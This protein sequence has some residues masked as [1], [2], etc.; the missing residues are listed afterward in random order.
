MKWRCREKRRGSSRKEAV[1]HS[2][3]RR[4]A[5]QSSAHENPAATPRGSQRGTAGGVRANALTPSAYGARRYLPSDLAVSSSPLSSSCAS[6]VVVA[7][8]RGPQDGRCRFVVCWSRRCHPNHV[9]T[10]ADAV[11]RMK[12]LHVRRVLLG[13]SRFVLFF[14]VGS[15]GRSRK[16]V[17]SRFVVVVVPLPGR[18]GSWY[19]RRGVLRRPFTDASIADL[20]LSERTSPES[21]L[22]IR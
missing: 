3:R 11:S 19:E 10:A 20:F 9:N 21:R 2:R 18:C 16:A 14:Q 13:L 12:F 4:G 1:K 22:L 15:V 5:E 6:C 17:S 8:S 7:A